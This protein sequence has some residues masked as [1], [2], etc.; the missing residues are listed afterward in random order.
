[1]PLRVP[2]AKFL[3]LHGAT[4]LA[5]WLVW[6]LAG[7]GAASPRHGIWVACSLLAASLF[8]P[9]RALHLLRRLRWL[10][11]AIAI[12]F[13]LGTPGRLLIDD[14]TA[15]PTIEGLRAA[16]HAALHL[17]AM[18]ACVAVLLERMTLPQLAGAMHR[19]LHPLSSERPGPDTFAL[20]LQ[21]V[22]RDLE[23]PPARGAWRS[24]LRPPEAEPAPLPVEPCAPLRAADALA[25]AL[26][27]AA[28]V[29][30]VKLG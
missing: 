24:W 25:I 22:L 20:R 7:Q 6:L 11:L 14:F 2:A 27:L 29:T 16:A 10:F 3:S 1:M 12:T 21:L 28:C 13:S 18:A 19:L 15:G 4:L 23:Q 9:R 26:A 8:A 30:W 5:I 17:A